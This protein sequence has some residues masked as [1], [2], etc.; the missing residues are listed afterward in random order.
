MHIHHLGNQSSVLNQ[1]VSEIRDETIQKDRLRFRTNIERIGMLLGY[2]LSKELP[3]EL[4]TIRTP[5]GMAETYLPSPELVI[6]SIL[7]AGLPL[8]QGLLAAFDQA[9]NSF[10]SAYRKHDLDGGSFDIEVEYLASPSLEDK[11]LILADPMLATG[12]SIVSVLE[13]LAPLGKPTELHIVSVIA[14]QPGIDYVQPHLPADAHLWV[15]A[16]DAT[17]NDKGY[18]LPGLG[19]AGDLAFGSKLQH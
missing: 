1:Y 13:A 19:D 4:T 7:R 11:I 9:D 18:I 15:A 8:H 17:L 6:C 16:I 12:K 14:A 10:I 5:L 3:S 2:E